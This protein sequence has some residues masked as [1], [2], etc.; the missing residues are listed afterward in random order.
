MP[1][2]LQKHTLN[3]RAGDYA[4][5][6]EVFVPKGKPASWVIQRLVSNF[7][8]RLDREIPPEEIDKI[9]GVDL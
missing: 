3:L 8:D 1:R 6:Q 9:E 5:L 7:V 4:R 2:N